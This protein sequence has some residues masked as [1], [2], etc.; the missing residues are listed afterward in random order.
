MGT[1]RGVPDDWGEGEWLDWAIELTDLQRERFFDD[2]DGGWY[3]TTGEDPDVLLRLKEDYDGAEP[4]ATSVTTRNLIRLAQ[5]TGDARFM[6]LAERT[7]PTVRRRDSDR[8]CA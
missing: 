1:H 8:S 6:D 3:S 4:S 2:C 5:L 7:L